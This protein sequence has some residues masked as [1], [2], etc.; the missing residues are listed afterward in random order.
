MKPLRT[1][2]L[3]QS[4]ISTLPNRGGVNR[5]IA[6]TKY[7]ISRKTG[8]RTQGLRLNAKHMYNLALIDKGFLR[9]PAFKRRGEENRRVVWVTQ[10]VTPGWFTE[11]LK[12]AQPDV[13]RKVN[14]AMEAVIAQ[15]QEG[16]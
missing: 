6:K 9:H 12:D 11:P 1:R 15:I 14:E 2:E 10:R 7:T 8:T 16:L 3:P 5:R 13:Q 4:A